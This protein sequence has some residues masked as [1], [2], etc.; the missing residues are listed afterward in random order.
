MPNAPSPAAIYERAR[1]LANIWM[2]TVDLQRRR[3]KEP[4]PIDNEFIFRR[5]SDFDFLAVALVRLKRA[6][7]LTARV[8]ELA[9]AIEAAIEKFD[10]S[11]P[12]L[13]DFRNVAEHFDEYAV[14]KGR[15]DYSRRQ[16]ETSQIEGGTLRWLGP[17]GDHFNESDSA[18]RLNV[19]EAYA[20]ARALF[21]AI[22]EAGKLLPVRAESAS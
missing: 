17:R 1:R 4:D 6:A 22:Q 20:A 19:D 15:A 3:L 10:S 5:W 13:T 18:G 16:L 14:D 21:T 7:R 8:A 9:P 11:L 2:W 12:H